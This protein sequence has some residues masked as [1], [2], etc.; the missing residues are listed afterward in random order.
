MHRFLSYRSVLLAGLLLFGGLS[1]SVLLYPKVLYRYRTRKPTVQAECKKLRSS[2]IARFIAQNVTANGKLYV[3]GGFFTNELQVT[4]RVDEYDL[5]TDSWRRLANLPIAVTHAGIA[6]DGQDV[7]L[8]GGFVGDHPGKAVVD[9]WIYN[10]EL[11][12]WRRGPALPEKRGGGAMVRLGR[13]LHYFGGLKEDRKTDSAQHWTLSLDARTHWENSSPLPEPRNHLGGAVLEGKIYAIGG[14]R[15]YKDLNW[16]H[17][18]DPI[19]KN[20]EQVASLSY[21]RSHF[22]TST[23][24]FDDKIFIVGG[25]RI[26]IPRLYDIH[27]YDPKIN[28]WRSMPALPQA[29]QSPIAKVLGNQLLVANGGIGPGGAYPISTMRVCELKPIDRFTSR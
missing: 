7:W 16:V 22:E 26:S 4:P 21:G 8:A 13:E 1:L 29:L 12:K 28:Q 5:K 18:Y 27:A 24:V 14:T 11:N 10:I 6:V 2:P 25:R 9:V 17:A 23:F 19:S 15:A 20:W 3:F